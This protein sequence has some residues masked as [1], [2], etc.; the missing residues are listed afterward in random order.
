MFRI[1]VGQRWIHTPWAG[2]LRALAEGGGGGFSPRELVDTIQLDVD[3]VD[4]TRGRVEGPLLALLG[5]LVRAAEEA[6]IGEQRLSGDASS[7][8]TLLRSGDGTLR[9]VI[10]GRGLALVDE[11]DFRRAV[12]EGV[13]AFLQSL[14]QIHPSLPEAAWAARLRLGPR[15]RRRPRSSPPSVRRNILASVPLGEG[16]LAIVDNPAA[17]VFRKASRDPWALAGLPQPV[18]ASVWDAIGGSEV[19]GSQ[20]SVETRTRRVR[21]GR[22]GS[23]PRAE[24]EDA[25]Q[26]LAGR[27]AVKLPAR[28]PLVEAAAL[29]L[30]PEPIPRRTPRPRSVRVPPQ[31]A[32]GL[33]RLS[34]R[35]VWRIEAS[36]PRPRLTSCRNG[37]LVFTSRQVELRSREGERRWSVPLHCASIVAG[38]RDRIAGGDGHGHVIVIEARTGERLARIRLEAGMRPT[39]YFSLGSRFVT[40][41]DSRLVGW[42]SSG[43]QVDWGFDSPSGSMRVVGFGRSCLAVDDGGHA[44]RLDE[45]G[46]IAFTLPLNLEAGASALVAAREA[47]ALV[48]GR[49]GGQA[50]LTALELATGRVRWRRTLRGRHAA[51]ALIHRSRVYVG[52][53]DD[54]GARLVTLDLASGKVVTETRVP[55]SEPTVA[56]P[57]GAGVVVARAGGGLCRFDPAGRLSWAHG[58]LDPDLSCSPA[59]PRPVVVASGLVVVAAAFVHVYELRG[60]RCVASLEPE[61]WA[62]EQLAL[63]DGPTIVSA[64]RDGLIEAWRST[65]HLRSVRPY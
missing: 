17:L 27:V 19:A 48:Q 63:L 26:R 15:R 57:C 41:E 65:G 35:P 62:P 13:E 4:V 6:F 11:D 37:L 31:L 12:R 5:S 51:R 7:G 29:E 58:A 18:L 14:A 40:G 42:S 22:A 34:L 56:W 23:F 49:D 54:E 9:I 30:E 55:G 61:E 32:D 24:L 43:R 44:V 64:G 21:L 47:V 8:V 20:L 59:T 45:A 52:V 25:L 36:S 39:A 16:E 53:D 10:D 60:G 2:L 50:I 28:D 33:R 38:S 46:R 1:R 3:G